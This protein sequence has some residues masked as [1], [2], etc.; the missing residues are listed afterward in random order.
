MGVRG[1]TWEHVFE[2]PFSTSLIKDLEIAYSQDGTTIFTKRLADCRIVDDKIRIE[3]SPQDTFLFEGDKT[4]Q[5]Q[6]RILDPIYN[7]PNSQI[8]DFIV[9]PSLFTEPMI[10]E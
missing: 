5:V 8:V 6:I 3:L 4:A 10:K 2:L 7:E 9:Y 1:A